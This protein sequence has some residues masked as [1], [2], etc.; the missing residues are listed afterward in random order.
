MVLQMYASQ[1]FPFFHFL[2]EFNEFFYVLEDAVLWLWRGHNKV[3]KRLKGEA[4]EDPHFP[5]Q[6]FPPP[7]ICPE[8]HG[9]NGF[10]EQKV[11]QFLLRYFSD[12]RI[13]NYKVGC[14]GTLNAKCSLTYILYIERGK[15]SFHLNNLL[16]N[17]LIEKEN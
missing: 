7:S 12:V 16:H 5:K 4:S 9:P 15:I 13:D 17:L 10:D 1:V 8:C 3:N 11:L 14:W 2:N 6:Q